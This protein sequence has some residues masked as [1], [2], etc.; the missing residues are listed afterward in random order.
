MILNGSRAQE[1]F[2]LT[3]EDTKSNGNRS[4]VKISDQIEFP[5]PIE[6]ITYFQKY[7]DPLVTT[8]SI[9]CHRPFVRF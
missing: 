1:K 8:L 6:L 2:A 3:N 7:A 4:S 5:G 9:P